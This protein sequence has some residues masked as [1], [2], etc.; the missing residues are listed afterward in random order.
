[1]LRVDSKKIEPGDTFIAI[2]SELRDG[3]DYIEDAID[4]GAACIIAEKGEYLVKTIIVKDT[5]VYLANYLKDLYENKL[6]K[7]KLIGITGTNGKTTSCYFIYQLLNRLGIKTAYIGTIG[8][9]VDDECVH[10]NNTTPDL[11]ELY[12]LLVRAADSGCEYVALEVS[13]QALVGRRLEGLEFDV[14][15]FTNLTIDHLDY[16]KTMEVYE[17]AKLE[18]FK[19]VR[20]FTIINMDNKFSNDFV[21]KENENILFGYNNYDYKISD[22]RIST[23]KSTFKITNGNEMREIVLPVLGVYNIYNYMYAYIICD[24]LN[25]DMNKVVSESASLTPPPGRYQII[26]NDK[27]TVIVDYAHTPDALLNIIKSARCYTKGRVITLIG[28]GGDRDKSKRLLMGKFATENSDFV[29]F[30]SDNPRTEDPNEI[31]NEMTNGLSK[32]NFEIIEDR[33]EAIKEAINYL[34]S[35]DILLVLGKGHEEYQ[36]IGKE[37]FHFSDAEEVNKYIK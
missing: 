34:N 10:L 8:F 9:Y 24:K 11:Y 20:G 28:C 1:M 19:M 21:L 18:L 30:T 33:K 5:K 23:E 22:V 16:H 36:I 27:N 6:N 29:F 4:R 2:K 3:H 35:T 13:S 7:L 17:K 31:L 15:G 26:K 12:D 14:A 25:L 32:N 37:K